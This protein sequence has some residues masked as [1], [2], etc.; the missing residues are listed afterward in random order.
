MN[1]LK[2]LAWNKKRSHDA[3]ESSA[4]HTKHFLLKNPNI[5]ARTSKTFTCHVNV[6]DIRKKHLAGPFWK[7]FRMKF[8]TP[9]AWSSNKFRILSRM[10]GSWSGLAEHH[11]QKLRQMLKKLSRMFKYL[12]PWQGPDLLNIRPEHCLAHE[13]R[14]PVVIH[15]DEV[16]LT[17]PP[18]H[19][20]LE[21]RLH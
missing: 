13:F 20:S 21:G 6:L 14:P 8:E 19:S 3:P 12:S 16:S 7:P 10:F 5:F 15:D 2:T 9:F 18:T 1:V 17:H 4:W 11:V